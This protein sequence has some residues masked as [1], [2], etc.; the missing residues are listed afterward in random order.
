MLL[1]RIFGVEILP[2][3]GS[4][5]MYHHNVLR[6]LEDGD[7]PLHGVLGT[8]EVIHALWKAKELR[9]RWKDAAGEEGATTPPLGMYDLGWIMGRILGGLEEAYVVA[10]G[11]VDGAA[12]EM[13]GVQEMQGEGWEWMVEESM[14]WEA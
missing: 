13:D 3:A 2:G 12:G 1:Q 7:N 14:D 9:N 6:A 4:V 8:G 5:H 11:R 10:R